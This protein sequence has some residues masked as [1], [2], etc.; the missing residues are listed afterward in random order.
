VGSL[1]LILEVVRGNNRL[2]ISEASV[3]PPTPTDGTGMNVWLEQSAPTSEIHP[4]PPRIKSSAR[5]STQGARLVSKRRQPRGGSQPSMRNSRC[6]L[7][8]SSSP[9]P[10]SVDGFAIRH[11]CRRGSVSPSYR[12]PCHRS[13]NST[14]LHCLLL[15]SFPLSLEEI[16][17]RRVRMHIDPFLCKCSIF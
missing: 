4:E 2:T 11:S 9:S 8:H 13:H 14:R 3:L 10:M 1:R 12:K 16:F 5:A 7:I 17:K 15:S 6:L